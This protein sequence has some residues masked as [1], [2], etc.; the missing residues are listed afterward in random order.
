MVLGQ[1]LDIAAENAARPPHPGRDHAVA[2][3]QDPGAL[4]TWSATCGARLAGAEMTAL[5]AYGDALGLAFQIADDVLDV[6]GDA[7]ALGK[8]VGQGTRRPG[9]ATF[10]SLLGL[11]AAKT[12][13]QEL[14]DTACGALSGYGAEAECLREAARF[15]IARKM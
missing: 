7:E 3:G 8:A 13:A 14:V 11:G 6:E 2:G 9:K 12:R 1:A 5:R 10:V 15:V 4:I